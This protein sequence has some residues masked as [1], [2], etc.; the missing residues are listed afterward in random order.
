M[1][2]TLDETYTRMLSFIDNL[3]FNEARAALEWLAFGFSPLSVAQLADACSIQIDNFQEP[4][5]EACG[6]EALVGL[7]S[8]LSLLIIVQ[9]DLSD[10]ETDDKTGDV[11][12]NDYPADSTQNHLPNKYDKAHYSQT[13]RLAHFSV[14][15]YLVSN[16]LRQSRFEL[17]RYA[18][19][20]TEVQLSLAQRGCAY[21]LY[22]TEQWNAKIWVDEAKSP[23]KPTWRHD[24]SEIREYRP[25]SLEDFAPIYTLLPYVC[26]H[27]PGHQALVELIEE[28]LPVSMRLHLRILQNDR[29]RTSWIRL[30]IH[31]SHFGGWQNSTALYWAAF[32]DLRQSVS[33]LCN[34]KSSQDINKAGRLHCT[35]LQA[36][37]SRGNEKVVEILI[38]SGADVN[39]KRGSHG[40]ALQAAA[41][42]GH[43]KIVDMLMA[44]GADVNCDAGSFGTAL[45]SAAWCGHEVVVDMLIANGA[46][47]R[48]HANRIGST[49]LTGSA[50]NGHGNIVSKLL[51][52]D[53]DNRTLNFRSGLGTALYQAARKGHEQIVEELFQVGAD[54]GDAMEIAT[55]EGHAGVVRVLIKYGAVYEPVDEV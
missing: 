8:V 1:P 27:W 25:N 44:N 7:F 51:K 53:V 30:H 13:V 3:Y 18:L 17:S 38:A 28:P 54:H 24:N 23:R 22:F 36:A 35:A 33:L 47:I 4:A 2:R 20:E 14:K 41:F 45:Q 42:L 21:L 49:A 37:T 46:D 40:T 9:D 19:R 43:T 52:V 5:F 6:Y 55:Q 34:S 26:T 15:E 10:H 29:A 48:Y 39:C 12:D 31:Y 32:L 16:R 50:M 11:V